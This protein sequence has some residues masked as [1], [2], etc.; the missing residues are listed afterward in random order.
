M[1]CGNHSKL[2]HNQIYS[3]RMTRTTIITARGPGTMSQRWL[4]PQATT[5]PPTL[6]PFTTHASSS[7]SGSPGRRNS[8]T[9]RELQKILAWKKLLSELKVIVEFLKTGQII[10]TGILVQQSSASAELSEKLAEAF[11]SIY[12]GV[13]GEQFIT[14]IKYQ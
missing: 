2:L 14:V 11:D 9:F 12:A 13:S 6:A 10:I 5:T 1:T 3:H 7:P 8:S 4:R